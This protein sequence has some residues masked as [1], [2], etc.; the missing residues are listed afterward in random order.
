MCACLLGESGRTV[1]ATFDRPRASSAHTDQAQSSPEHHQNHILR[2]DASTI[3]PA[4]QSS[5]LGLR[6]PLIGN[7]AMHHRS[8]QTSWLDS[9]TSLALEVQIPRIYKEKSSDQGRAEE[10]S[11]RAIEKEECCD[12][13]EEVKLEPIPKEEPRS[14]RFALQQHGI[15][16]GDS[17][18]TKTGR[19]TKVM[20]TVV[21]RSHARTDLRTFQGKV[22]EDH[23]SQLCPRPWCQRP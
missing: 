6:P 4:L 23:S 15:L 2:S 14:R 5:L 12:A 8:N 1:A 20:Q 9:Q 7:F 21:N 11:E 18:M 17:K 10:K 13:V 19:G 16:I 22:C 3:N